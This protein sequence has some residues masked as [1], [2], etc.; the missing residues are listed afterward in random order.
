M[1]S[2]RRKE[3]KKMLLLNPQI[4]RLGDCMFDFMLLIKH[5][6]ESKSTADPGK[7]HKIS[8]IKTEGRDYKVKYDPRIEQAS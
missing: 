8:S 7:C 6:M 1:G 2:R 4:I 5:N 3:A